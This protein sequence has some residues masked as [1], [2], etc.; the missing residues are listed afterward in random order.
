MVDGL[1][2]GDY[3]IH[4][5][6]GKIAVKTKYN[7]GVVELKM[8]WFDPDEKIPKNI[9]TIQFNGNDINIKKN[10]N[11]KNKDKCCQ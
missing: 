7:R 5:L 1:I 9:N 2:H 11:I 10:L 8:G 6:D 3:I 4:K